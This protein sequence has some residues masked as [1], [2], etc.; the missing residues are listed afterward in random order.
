M[1]NYRN[2]KIMTD[3][4]KSVLVTVGM[5]L[6]IFALLVGVNTLMNKNN[7]GKAIEGYELVD[8]AWKNNGIDLETGSMVVNKG[9]MYSEE[10][11]C[12]TTLKIDRDFVSGISYVVF[13][14]DSLGNLVY[15]DTN[16]KSTSKDFKGYTK[17]YEKDV[18]TIELEDGESIDHARI[19]MK[20]IEDDNDELNIFER[21]KLTKGLTVYV[22]SPVDNTIEETPEVEEE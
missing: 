11:E 4:T 10:I 2:K 14:Y 12:T 15:V 13:Y 1:A 19:L 8:V 3:K 21:N 7:N 17:D 20:W 22:S 18:T 5:I 9:F 6:L 16:E